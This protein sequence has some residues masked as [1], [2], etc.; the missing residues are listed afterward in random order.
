MRKLIFLLLAAS[1][2]SPNTYAIGDSLKSDTL[3]VLALSGLQMFDK[4]D[5]TVIANVPY[6]ASVVAY[7]VRPGDGIDT[8]ENIPGRITRVS[9]QGKEGYLFNGFL[10]QLPAPDTSVKNLTAYCERYFQKFGDPVIFMSTWQPERVVTHIQF[11]RYKGG[12]QIELKT[13]EPTWNPH[14]KMSVGS[15]LLTKDLFLVAKAI[16][17]HLGADSLI[18]PQPTRFA[19]PLGDNRDCEVDEKGPCFVLPHKLFEFGYQLPKL[20]NDYFPHLGIGQTEDESYVKYYL[21]A[22]E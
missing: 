14:V 6:G 12:S 2:F 10:S 1:L 11:Y 9:W 22:G 13:D 17:R 15:P 7:G 3:N 18:M 4:P 8:I 16:F 19:Y 20:D 5:G 21:W